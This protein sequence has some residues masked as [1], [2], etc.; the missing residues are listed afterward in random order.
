MP[1]KRLALCAAALMLAA[2]D[3]GDV[4]RVVESPLSNITYVQD[5]NTN[6]CFAARGSR[7]YHGWMTVSIAHVPCTPEVL[8]AIRRNRR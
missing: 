8:Q 1:T 2:C 4:S 5:A 7:T 3:P 6:L